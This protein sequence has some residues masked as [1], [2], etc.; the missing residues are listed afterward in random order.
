MSISIKLLLKILPWLIALILGGFIYLEFAKGDTKQTVITNNSVLQ[1]I[2]A[3]GKLELIKYNFKEITQ[4]NESLAEFAG[5]KFFESNIVLISRG[6][7]VGCVDLLKMEQEDVNLEGDTV[8]VRLPYPEMCHYK[9]DLANTQIFS[10]NTATFSD[11]REFI[12]KA[13]AVAEEEIKK[14]ALNSGILEQAQN[15]AALVLKPL[16]ENASGG[17]AV[18]IDFKVKEPELLQTEL[19]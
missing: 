19:D 15:N 14:S 10:L 12:K 9:L 11:D 8:F 2:E 17:K 5:I 7:A 13:Y 16:L 4:L 18:V 1:E 3:L 6:E